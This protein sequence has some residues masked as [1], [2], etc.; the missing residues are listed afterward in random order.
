LRARVDNEESGPERTCV[1]SGLKG[2][3]ET[4]LRFAL[5][6]EGVVAPDILRKLPGRGVWTRLNRSVVS[7]AV[8]KQAFSRGFRASVRA[9][10][11][12][13]DDVDR[14][15][16]QD[17]LRFLS[18][19]NKAGL[20]VVGGAKVEAAI[21]AGGLLALIHAADGALDGASKLDRLLK[22]CLGERSESVARINLFE[23]HQ[24]DL[25]LGRTNVIH[26]ALNA[27]PA[28]AAFLAKVARLILYRSDE[29]API[30]ISVAADA[31]GAKREIADMSQG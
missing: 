29:A 8:A 5:S 1:V 6:G 11:D 19:V 9:T 4:M 22:G 17:A 16:E 27:G 7:R 10:P 15:L 13:A 26:A 30:A 18:L 3:P 25:A 21:R 20:V 14:L 2:S 24:L 23:S 12:L 28:S 31:D